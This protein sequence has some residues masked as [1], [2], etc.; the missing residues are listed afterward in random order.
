MKFNKY[1]FLRLST[2]QTKV[3][4]SYSNHDRRK[5][6]SEIF[7]QYQDPEFQH[8]ATI[9]YSSDNCG[10]WYSQKTIQGRKLVHKEI[11][12]LASLASRLAKLDT[13]P[14]L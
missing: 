11:I 13:K 5:S 10:I 3:V 2:E 8:L 6:F 9:G 12:C 4:L 1:L 7:N 14:L